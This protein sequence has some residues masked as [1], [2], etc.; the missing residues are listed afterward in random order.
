MGIKAAYKTKQNNANTNAD[1]NVRNKKNHLF[2]FTL[3]VRTSLIIVKKKSTII[4]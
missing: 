2:A 1:T 3:L 4:K